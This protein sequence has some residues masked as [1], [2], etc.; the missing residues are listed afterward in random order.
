MILKDY[1]KRALDTVRG[2]LDKLSESKDKALR[3]RE[4]DPELN[5]GLGTQCP[6]SRA[7][8]DRIVPAS[9]YQPRR[10]GFG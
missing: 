10:S 2:Y 4:I 8:R 7:S 3:V 9:A 5:V 6:G 1:Q